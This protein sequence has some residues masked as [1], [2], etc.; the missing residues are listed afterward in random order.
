MSISLDSRFEHFF[1]SHNGLPWL[2]YH[3]TKTDLLFG[4]YCFCFYV[5]QLNNLASIKIVLGVQCREITLWG[6]SLSD[7]FLPHF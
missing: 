2:Q 4:Q 3:I 6:S 1:K 5:V 7:G